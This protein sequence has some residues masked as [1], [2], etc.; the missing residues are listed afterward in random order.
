MAWTSTTLKAAIQSYLQTT[1]DEFVGFLDTF[2]VQAEDRI[3]KAV[4]LPVNRKSQVLTLTM[5]EPLADLPSDFLYPFELR[6]SSSGVYSSVYYVDVSLIREA[7][8][9]PLMIG[10][11]RWYSMY[12]S[13]NIVMGPTPSENISGWLS[14]FY[15]PASITTAGTS[16]LGDRAE[17]CLLY[18]CLA[19]AYSYLKG[20]TDLM[21]LYDDRFLAAL[22]DLKTLGE[23]LDLGDAF[24]MGEVRS[25]R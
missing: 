24:R 3:S 7:Y 14:Y 22:A 20:E 11:P 2:I 1:D 6:I 19:E 9:N 21:K 17:N 16:W 15:K 12:D 10:V 18:A 23:G 5:G 4:I 8:P 13:T 25:A